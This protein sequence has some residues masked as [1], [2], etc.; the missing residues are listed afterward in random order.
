MLD[1]W[2]SVAGLQTSDEDTKRLARAEGHP[3]F[4]GREN[5]P[6]DYLNFI[7]KAIIAR[8]AG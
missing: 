4:L 1:K 7:S 6:I 8:C 2:W 3:V 5:I